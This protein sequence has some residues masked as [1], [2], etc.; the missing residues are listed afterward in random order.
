MVRRFARA[1]G[2]RTIKMLAGAACMDDLGEMVV[3]G[4]TAIEIDYLRHNEWAVT[5][6][7]I[8]WRRSK[9]GV[10]LTAEE[11]VKVAVWLEQHA[12]P[13]DKNKK[14]NKAHATGT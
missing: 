7:D 1:Y 2:A 6:D 14:E 10:H 3:P 13:V 12:A 11:R 8:L 4:L 9:L 5:A